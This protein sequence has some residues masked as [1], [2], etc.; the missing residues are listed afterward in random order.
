MRRA[1][2]AVGSTG[3]HGYQRAQT[4]V[5]R[6]FRES[7]RQAS[8]LGAYLDT[9]IPMLLWAADYGRFERGWMNG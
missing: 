5:G 1:K 2:N 3:N 9:G 8:T 7:V 6:G 4:G